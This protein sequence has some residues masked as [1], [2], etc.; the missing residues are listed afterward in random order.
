MA[1]V[2]MDEG[3]PQY[4]GTTL[5]PIYPPFSFSTLICVVHE[6]CFFFG[7]HNKHERK[8]IIGV[9]GGN[10]SCKRPRTRATPNQLQKN[11]ASAI[12]N[13]P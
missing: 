11:I 9:E 1:R 5:A 10:L 3:V 8:F 13:R 6:P 7:G 12:L 2:S 4:Y